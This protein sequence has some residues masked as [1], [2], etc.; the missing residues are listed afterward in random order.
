MTDGLD[1]DLQEVQEAAPSEP[2][3]N[4]SENT[5]DLLDK[6]TV[7]KIVARERQRRTKKVNRRH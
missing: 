3:Q 1:T 2:V 7:S 4:E 5:A 6:A